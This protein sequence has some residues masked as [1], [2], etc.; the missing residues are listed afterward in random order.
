MYRL[1]MF[2]AGL[3]LGVLAVLLLTSAAGGEFLDVIGGELAWAE[4]SLR[5]AAIMFGGLSFA[6]S[7]VL[8]GLAMGRWK[9]P[10]PTPSPEE[11]QH[12]GLQE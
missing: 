2:I 4:S 10:M 3:L 5:I 8:M 9:R 6:A 1:I 12:H 7:L 11:R